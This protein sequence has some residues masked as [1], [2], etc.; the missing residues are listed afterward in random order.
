MCLLE[1]ADGCTLICMVDYGFLEA[2]HVV[3]F[4][5]PNFF[6]HLLFAADGSPSLHAFGVPILV[7]LSWDMHLVLFHISHDLYPRTYLLER[8]KEKK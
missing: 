3:S 8:K 2:D 1:D 7:V 4:V 6:S 5:L